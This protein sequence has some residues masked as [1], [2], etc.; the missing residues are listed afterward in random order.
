M[1]ASG[2]GA[3]TLVLTHQFDCSEGKRC[4]V[5]MT[6][7]SDVGIASLFVSLNIDSVVMS[8]TNECYTIEVGES[9]P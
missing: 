1:L 2:R 6:M 4:L 3:A 8:D 7:L 5:I 9:K